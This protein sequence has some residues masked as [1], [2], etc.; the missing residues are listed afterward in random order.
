MKTIAISIKTEPLKTLTAGMVN[1]LKGFLVDKRLKKAEAIKAY[2]ESNAYLS[3]KHTYQRTHAEFGYIFEI[4]ITDGKKVAVR[5]GERHSLEFLEHELRGAGMIVGFDLQFQLEFILRRV[6][7]TDHVDGELRKMLFTND[8]TATT[9]TTDIK[10]T[11][12]QADKSYNGLTLAQLCMYN[13]YPENEIPL[14]LEA[15][16]VSTISLYRKMQGSLL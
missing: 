10:K 14:T 9:A 3:K 8:G 4:A 5:T 12:M 1:M 13:G 6:M 2:Q 11:W 16:A 15:E 7:L